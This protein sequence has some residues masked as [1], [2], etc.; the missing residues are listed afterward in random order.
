MLRFGLKRTLG[1]LPKT[2]AASVNILYSKQKYE[3]REPEK[4]I[5]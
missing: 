4:L 5:N 3:V 2:G 1:V